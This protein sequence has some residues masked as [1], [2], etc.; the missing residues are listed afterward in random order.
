MRVPAT[1]FCALIASVVTAQHVDLLG[2]LPYPVRANDVWGYEDSAGTEYALIGVLNGTSIVDITTDSTHPTELFFVPGPESIW[3]DIKTWNGRAYVTNE[4]GKGLLIID[5]RQLPASIDTTSYS[6][7]P[8]TGDTLRTAHNI[9][10]DENGFAYLLGSNLGAYIL[11]LNNDPDQPE[12]AGRYDV[13]YVHDAFVRGDTMWTAEIYDGLLGVVDVADKANPVVI[14]TTVTPYATTHNCWL[15][16]DGRYAFTTDERSGAPVAAFD[17][18]DITDIKKLDE[19]YSHP[20]SGVI[21]HNT[22][23]TDNNLVTAWY[24]DGVVIADAHR[25]E[26]LV[27]TGTFDTSPFPSGDGYSGCWGVYPYF[28]SGKIV[29]SDI[30]EGLFVLRPHYRRA[31]YLE[32]TVTTTVTSLPVTGA[33]VEIITTSVVDSTNITGSFATGTADSGTYIARF[34]HPNC[35]TLIVQDVQLQPGQVTTLN[36]QMDCPTLDTD[37]LRYASLMWFDVSASSLRWNEHD[38]PVEL[39]V[40]SADGRIIRGATLAPG[41]THWNLGDLP[42]GLYVAALR[43][44]DGS[45]SVK[46]TVL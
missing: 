43:A 16:D 39:T 4:T 26:N 29:A 41:T 3:R 40:W 34:S 5:L 35:L 10:I 33:Q 27:I 12:Y 8:S 14:G 45:G 30:Q 36:V 22:F 19:L 9:F 11:D 21:P 20:G 1:T 17:V 13:H 42:N 7:E 15:S 38:G 37:S 2:H 24:R 23:W 46:F 6:I 25:P 44:P 32:G 28:S 18:S 31:C